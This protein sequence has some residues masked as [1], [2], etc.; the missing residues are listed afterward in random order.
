M[1]GYM[2]HLYAESLA[3]FG[4]PRELPR[5]GG[6]ILERPIPGSPFRDAMGCYPLFTC[7]DW[8]RLEAD[9]DSL[10]Q[11]LVSLALVADPF[12][13]YDLAYLQHCFDVVIPFK[14]HT[15]VDLNLPITENVIPHHQRKVKKALQKISVSRCQEPQ[16]YVDDWVKLYA[17]L[18]AR[19]NITGV[20]R[21]SPKAFIQQFKIP[22][23]AVFR[24]DFGGA[25]IGMKIWYL[26]GE[27]GY[28]HLAAYSQLGY[29]LGASYALFWASIEHLTSQG[30]R[31]LCLGAGAGSKNDGADGLTW[32]KRGWSPHTRTAYFCGRIFDQA[33]YSDLAAAAGNPDTGYFPPYRCGEFNSLTMRLSNE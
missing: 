13:K 7:R 26:Q 24:A 22:G 23:L 5:C 4:V 3:D 25:T 11:D 15:I 14:E 2:H 20:S 17:A 31:W 27:V 30:L 18:I 6:W 8:P 16:D 19:H 32:F 12:G 21:F 9:L 28:S 10:Q 29:K 33:I 1:T